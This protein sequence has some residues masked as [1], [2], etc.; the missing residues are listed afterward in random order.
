MLPMAIIRLFCHMASKDN[1]NS[2]KSKSAYGTFWHD[3]LSEFR[4]FRPSESSRRQYASAYNGI[5]IL[6]WKTGWKRV[7]D[8]GPY[9][10][11]N[12]QLVG[13]ANS[14]SAET[15]TMPVRMRRTNG[16]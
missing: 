1:I 6:Y 15:I 16:L 8:A 13:Y 10:R 2:L 7:V 14:L 4:W 11:M 9:M 5:V 12:E 3:Y